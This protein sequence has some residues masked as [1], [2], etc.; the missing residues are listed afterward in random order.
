MFHLLFLP[1]TSVVNAV[2]LSNM[3]YEVHFSTVAGQTF[4]SVIHTFG[5]LEQ[6]TTFH[7]ITNI[8]ITENSLVFVQNLDYA[9]TKE[10]AGR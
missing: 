9:M 6:S 1:L 2:C 7:P 4:S 8:L 5:Y 3:N 10:L